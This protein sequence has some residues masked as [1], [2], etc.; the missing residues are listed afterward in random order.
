MFCVCVYACMP[1]CIHVYVH[2]Y[3]L[4]C[5]HRMFR[6][7][8]AKFMDVIRV[9]SSKKMQYHHMP[10]YQPLHSYDHFSVSLCQTVRCQFQRTTLTLTP[11]S[12]T[13]DSL[14]PPPLV[15]GM[16]VNTVQPAGQCNSLPGSW[17]RCF[18][19]VTKFLAQVTV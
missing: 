8:C 13:H 3:I 16:F 7:R 2:V 10:N 11:T 12:G 19:C 14:V 17:L 18:A 1:V 15:Y 9:I 4:I 5:V 6:I